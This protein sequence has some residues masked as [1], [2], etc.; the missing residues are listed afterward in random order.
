M[1]CLHKI[2]EIKKKP[3]IQMQ[4]KIHIHVVTNMCHDIILMVL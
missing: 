2:E 3:E 4:M 1:K